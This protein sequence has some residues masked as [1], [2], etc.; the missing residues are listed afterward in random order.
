M[1]LKSPQVSWKNIQLGCQKVFLDISVKNSVKK[2]NFL[3][4]GK[5]MKKSI[6]NDFS[7]VDR[8]PNKANKTTFE[9]Y[10]LK[11]SEILNY[12]TRKGRL[13]FKN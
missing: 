11:S 4:N 10:L 9:K 8:L 12:P 6:P 13:T 2:K 5:G 7:K 3:S 1:S